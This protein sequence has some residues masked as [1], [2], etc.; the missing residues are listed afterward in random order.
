MPVSGGVIH[1][2]RNAAVHRM[3]SAVPPSAPPTTSS[4]ADETLNRA[5]PTTACTTLASVER[6]NSPA[7]TSTMARYAIPNVSPVPVNACA[8]LGPGGVG[9]FVA[10]AF[11]RAGIPVTVV[12]RE[13]TAELIAREGIRVESV[14]LG[15]TWIARPRAVSR[16]EEPVE[17]L[18]VAPKYT[19]LAESLDRISGDP[20][21]VVPM[22][23]GLDHLAVLRERF[24]EDR[25]AAA[26]IRI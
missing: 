22:L 19:T 18:V 21:M 12:A 14:R 15:D 10:G 16:L 9:G 1:S 11:E 13:E 6:A 24:G 2:S 4:A 3:Y 17:F 23:N 26:S 5:R 7:C 8:M 20:G 25:V